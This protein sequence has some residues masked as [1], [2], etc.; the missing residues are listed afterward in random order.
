M[1]DNAAANFGWNMIGPETGSSTS[2]RYNSRENATGSPVLSIEYTEGVPNESAAWG[3]VKG[4]F[5]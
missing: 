4:L 1:P 2:K 5:R 3:R